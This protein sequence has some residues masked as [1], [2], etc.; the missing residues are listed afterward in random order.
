LQHPGSERI[1]ACL[2]MVDPETGRTHVEKRRVRSNEPGQPRALTFSCSRPYAF[3]DRDRTRAW[4]CEA[5]DEARTELAFQLW[6]YVVMPEHVHVLVYPGDAPERLSGFLQAVK[7]PVAR[8]AIRYLKSHAPEWLAR[9]TVREG[10]RLRHRFWQPGGGYD[11]NITST[12]ALRAA[13]DYIH[14]NP[15]RRGLVATAEVWEWSSARWYA[16]LRPVQMGIDQDVLTELARGGGG[17]GFHTPFAEPQG[18]PPAAALGRSS[19]SRR[20][21]CQRTAESN[22][23]GNHANRAPRGSQWH[24]LQFYGCLRAPPVLGPAFW[25]LAAPLKGRAFSI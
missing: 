4:F 18:V 1:R 9:G 23:G 24:Q 20:L 8:K 11:R 19:A 2:R 16:G 25:G 12:K 14:A 7:E 17:C 6:A 3:L 10:A 15:V 21:P 5:L 22:S 13:I